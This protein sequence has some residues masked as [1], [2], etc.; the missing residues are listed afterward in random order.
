MTT[1]LRQHPVELADTTLL[2]GCEVR[3]LRR[4][5]P[6]GQNR[7]KV[8]TAV[9]L[10]HRGTGLVAEANERRSQ[11]ENRK[12]AL[13]R[14]RMQLAL[15]VRAPLL[16]G[17]SP[18]TLWQG[19]CRDGK[20]SVSPEHADFPRLLAEALDHL[21]ATKWDVPEAAYGLGCTSSQLIKLL[22]QEPRAL[23]LVNRERAERGLRRLH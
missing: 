17:A 5:G 13:R 8:E 7:N 16:S 22:G 15:T 9:Q 2:E 10:V 3:R 20:V 23:A 6:G 21:A 19:R 14:L 4:S 1:K 18:S 11:A 12:A